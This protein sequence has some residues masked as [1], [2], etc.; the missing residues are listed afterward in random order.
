MN[1]SPQILMAISAVV[2]SYSAANTPISLP[3]GYF[4]FLFFFFFLGGGGQK[5]LWETDMLP[6]ET[7]GGKCNNC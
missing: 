1:N 2:G 5:T 4:F 7:A 6:G 3:Q